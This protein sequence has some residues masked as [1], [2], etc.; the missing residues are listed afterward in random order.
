[1]R[2]ALNN[3]VPLIVDTFNAVRLR[4]AVP[5]PH[6]YGLVAIFSNPSK[7]NGLTDVKSQRGI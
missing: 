4:W 5:T 7:I 1:M 3:R 6:N 2:L